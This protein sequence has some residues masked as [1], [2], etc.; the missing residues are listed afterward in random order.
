MFVAFIRMRKLTV[1]F[2]M[3]AFACMEHLGSP[4]NEFSCNFIFE[5]F[6]DDRQG[7]FKPVIYM[8]H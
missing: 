7:S 4:L 6:A 2:I 5:V 8:A 1:K 3:S